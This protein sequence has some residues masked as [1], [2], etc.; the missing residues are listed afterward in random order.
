ME[1]VLYVQGILSNCINYIIVVVAKIINL[2]MSV[3]PTSPFSNFD[4][5]LDEF[6]ITPML[7]YIA[8]FIP[9]S[10]FLTVLSIWLTCVAVYYSYS[11][12]SKKVGLTD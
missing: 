11:V 9:F 7:G 5:K 2:L 6:G 12:I 3:F 1:V 8:Y 4:L 10:D